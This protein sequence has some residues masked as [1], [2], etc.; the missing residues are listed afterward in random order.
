MRNGR[1]TADTVVMETTT[2]LFNLATFV[3]AS[4]EAMVYLLRIVER[5]RE[6][7]FYRIAKQ[8]MGVA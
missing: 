1:T 4:R 3:I 2:L 5:K 8:S 6:Q 7:R